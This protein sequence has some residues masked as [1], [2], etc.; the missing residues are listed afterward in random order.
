VTRLANISGTEAVRAFE[1]AGY[2]VNRQTASHIILHCEGHPPLTIPDHR[3]LA[4]NLLRAQ[5]KLAGLTVEEF[6]RLK[7]K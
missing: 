7:R 4:P 6:L 1:K 5:I 3:E 2:R